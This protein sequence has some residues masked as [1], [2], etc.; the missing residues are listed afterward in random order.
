MQHTCFENCPQKSG[1][2]SKPPKI[3]NF[4]RPSAQPPAGVGVKE[5]LW[6]FWRQNRQKTHKN[7]L[8]PLS[9]GKGGRG[10]GKTLR[11]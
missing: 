1:T 10:D 4:P 3:K 11:E 2:S 9:K 7:F 8:S 5:F 6:V